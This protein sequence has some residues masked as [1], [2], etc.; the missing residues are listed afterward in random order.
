MS[1]ASSQDT[2]HNAALKVLERLCGHVPCPQTFQKVKALLCLLQDVVRV[3]GPCN[4]I[5]DH[6]PQESEAGDSMYS[7][8]VVIGEWPS[9]LLMIFFGS[10]F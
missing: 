10:F 3:V 8:S 4:V 1:N 9:L 5:S 2:V 6:H 7:S